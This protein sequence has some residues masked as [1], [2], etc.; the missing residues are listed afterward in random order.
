[1]F[2]IKFLILVLSALLIITLNNCKKFRTNHSLDKIEFTVD[3]STIEIK[4]TISLKSKY[5]SGSTSKSDS[6][7]IMYGISSYD[8]IN[9]FTFFIGKFTHIGDGNDPVFSELEKQ[10]KPGYYSFSELE[11]V[12]CIIEWSNQENTLWRSD[13]YEQPSSSY[14][15][16]EKVIL[17]RPLFRRK[18]IKDT[19][20]DT[21]FNLKI[22]G[23][24]SCSVWNEQGE[25]KTLTD[26]KIK[27]VIINRTN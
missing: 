16:I 3:G 25:E 15:E 10:I 19:Q 22:K 20:S 27:L 8:G 6:N 5:R 24:F 1:M 12:Q 7:S 2:K 21:Y 18:S 17:A 4:E 13:L 9:S 23:K 26:G 11:T 14:L